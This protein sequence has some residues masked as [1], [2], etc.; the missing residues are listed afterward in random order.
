M[1]TPRGKNITAINLAV[2]AA[3]LNVT[4]VTGILQ[5]SVVLTGRAVALTYNVQTLYGTLQST[6]VYDPGIGGPSAQ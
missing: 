5:S 4:G 6:F 2:N 3:L 1:G